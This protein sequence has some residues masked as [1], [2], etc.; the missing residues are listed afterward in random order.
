MIIRAPISQAQQ[1]AM[2]VLLSHIPLHGW[3]L[4]A[5]LCLL[6]AISGCAPGNDGET[7]P[8]RFI[9]IPCP[10][11]AIE[12]GALRSEITDFAKSGQHI[13]VLVANHEKGFREDVPASGILSR[14]RAIRGVENAVGKAAAGS[15][16]SNAFIHEAYAIRQRIH[17]SADSSLVA[18]QVLTFGGCEIYRQAARP[19]GEEEITS[20][21]GVIPAQ[22]ILEVPSSFHTILGSTLWSVTALLLVVLGAYGWFQLGRVTQRGKRNR[23]V[24]GH[25]TPPDARGPLE[26]GTQGR[27]GWVQM[28]K[29]AN[30]QPN[31]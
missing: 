25:P 8:V 12:S 15:A 2:N 24:D 17:G 18:H 14:R 7:T 29:K 27:R 19:Q 5:L 6:P 20:R 26:R 3:V 30:Q 31:K 21:P 11:E 16:T 1:Q 4:A 13:I 22:P 23:P 9:E 10:H 28:V